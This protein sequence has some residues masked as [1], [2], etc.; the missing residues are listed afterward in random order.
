MTPANPAQLYKKAAAFS[1]SPG[2]LV[3]MLYD[4][5]LRFC[6]QAL[7][8]LDEPDFIRS[9]EITHNN[10]VRAQAILTE[11]QA[12]LN[13]EKGEE[14][15]QT[16]FRLYDYMQTEL[17]KANRDRAKE[18]LNNVIRFLGEIRDS[19]AEMLAAQG[20]PSTRAG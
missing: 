1:A 3:L 11:L 8:G 6:R 12:T 19:W 2:Q 4:G 16:L 13:F 14:L 15:A 5:A 17:L 10:I 20:D 7:E 9:Q 18:P